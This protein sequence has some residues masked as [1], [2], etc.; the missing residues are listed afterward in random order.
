MRIDIQ[1]S[2]TP[3]FVADFTR[4]RARVCLGARASRVESLSLAFTSVAGTTSCRAVLR[5]TAGEV[6][7]A[8]G[9]DASMFRAI[10]LAVSRVSAQLVPP[11]SSRF[12]KAG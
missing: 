7:S 9:R 4:E 10:E 3:P 8:E 2:P 1:M 6:Q 12:P 11:A 5:T